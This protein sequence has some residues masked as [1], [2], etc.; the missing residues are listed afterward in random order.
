MKKL[1]DD[2]AVQKYQKQIETIISLQTIDSGVSG[3]KKSGRPKWRPLWLVGALR[4]CP[5]WL[6]FEKPS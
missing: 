1:P 2:T 3:V 6:K 4:F 5:N